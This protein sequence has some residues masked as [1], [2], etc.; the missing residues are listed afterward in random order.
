MSLRVRYVFRLPARL[1]LGAWHYL[2]LGFSCAG[3]VSVRQSESLPYTRMLLPCFQQLL[4]PSRILPRRPAPPLIT[5][6]CRG[7]SEE[8]IPMCNETFINL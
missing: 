5:A 1:F 3:V 2:W 4:V 8:D 7:M 6:V